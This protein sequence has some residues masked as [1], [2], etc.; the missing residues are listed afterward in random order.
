M[1]LPDG[2]LAAV[3]RRAAQEGTTVTSL[4]EQALR[5]LLAKQPIDPAVEPLPTYDVAG[6]SL[7]VDLEDGDAVYELLDADGAE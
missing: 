5:D 2:L 7:L 1:N 3:R 6:S 4:V